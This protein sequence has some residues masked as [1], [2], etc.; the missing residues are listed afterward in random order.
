MLAV[1]P[2]FI[3]PSRPQA[4]Q[5]VIC[6]ATL[7]VTDLVVMSGYTL[8]A[9]RSLRLLRDARHLRWINRVFGTLF[10]GLAMLL[11]TFRSEA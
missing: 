11:A 9:A 3:D 7:F 4:V 1:L 10:I 6:G 2:Q 8:F 5:Y